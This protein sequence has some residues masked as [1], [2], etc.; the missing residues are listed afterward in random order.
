MRQAAV[1]F[2]VVP[3]NVEGIEARYLALMVVLDRHFAHWPYL[4]G[5]RPSI[6]DFSLMAPMYGHLGRDPKPLSL[7]QSKAVHL[8]RWVE[9][10]NRPEPDTGEFVEAGSLMPVDEFAPNDEVPETLV[11][12]MRQLAVDFVPETIAAAD[13]IDRW[14][15]AHEDLPAGTPLERG[16]GLASFEVE[17]RTINALAQPYRFYLLNRV[18]ADFDAMAPTDKSLVE[19][20]LEECH[21]LPVIDARLKRDIGRQDNREIWL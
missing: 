20:M 13:F 17:G 3:E 16:V 9:R 1:A 14:L 7:M 15:D 4:L 21:L 5:G 8:F 18:H 11:D 6:G 19:K 2:G 12:V 10:M